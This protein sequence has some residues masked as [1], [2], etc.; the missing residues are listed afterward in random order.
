MTSRVYWTCRK[1]QPKSTLKNIDFF[2]EQYTDIRR[3][4]LWVGQQLK[5]LDTPV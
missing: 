2:Q 3:Q 5:D 4:M 1:M